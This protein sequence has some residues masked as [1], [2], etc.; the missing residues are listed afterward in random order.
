MEQNSEPVKINI[1]KKTSDLLNDEFLL[2][3]RGKIIATNKG[4]VQMYFESRFSEK[5]EII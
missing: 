5:A 1:S 2:V 3:Y 4:A